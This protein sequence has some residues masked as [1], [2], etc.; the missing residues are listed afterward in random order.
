MPGYVF[1][2][3]DPPGANDANPFFTAGLSPDL[4]VREFL[5]AGADG[6]G[7]L[8]AGDQPQIC[9]DPKQVTFM[10]SYPNYMPLNVHAIRHIEGC[11]APLPYDRIYG[12]FFTR[13]K[14]IIPTGAKEVVRRSVD[15][16]MEAIRG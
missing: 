15:R 8:M 16:Y 11:L 7:A 6:R 1:A 14:G 12:A 13:G 9:M 2:S 5:F 3:D 10:Y 4:V